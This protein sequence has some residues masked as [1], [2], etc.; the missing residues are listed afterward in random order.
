[1]AERYIT[2]QHRRAVIERAERRCEYCQCW[3]AYAIQSFDVDHIVPVSRGGASTPDNLAYACSGCNRHKLNRVE[4]Y[5]LVEQQTVAL[6]HPRRDR[7]Q[8]HFQ[9]NEDYTFM[10][11]LTATGRVTVSALQLN[12][13]GVVNL[14]RLLRLIGQ[15]PPSLGTDP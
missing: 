5:D 12:R 9:W 11:G 7:W 10:I 15:H 2:A 13:E 1:M 3:A 14:R 6:F 8:E 4:A